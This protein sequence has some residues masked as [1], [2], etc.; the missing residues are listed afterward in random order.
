MDQRFSISDLA[1]RAGFSSSHFS[2]RFRT[3]TGYSVTECVQRLRMARARRML[4]T[5]GDPVAAIAET[6]G[7]SDPFYFTRQFTTVNGISPAF[8]ANHPG[9]DSARPDKPS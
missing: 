5:T 3:V 7:Y 6:V 1:E 9:S 8:R 2:A 4:I